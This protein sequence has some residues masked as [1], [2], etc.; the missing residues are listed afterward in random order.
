VTLRGVDFASV[1]AQVGPAGAFAQKHTVLHNVLSD[2]SLHGHIT[3][4]RCR[5]SS[6]YRLR[7]GFFE[8]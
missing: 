2:N 6:S 1:K 4:S 8:L 5:G 3:V 7:R